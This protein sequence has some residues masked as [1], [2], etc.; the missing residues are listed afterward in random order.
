MFR[1]LEETLMNRE[2]ERVLLQAKLLDIHVAAYN[3]ICGAISAE[4]R[5]CPKECKQHNFQE[6]PIAVT[7]ESMVNLDETPEIELLNNFC[8]TILNSVNTI[9]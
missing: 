4:K 2:S 9:L 7:D 8:T 5:K 1:E 3:C 6:E